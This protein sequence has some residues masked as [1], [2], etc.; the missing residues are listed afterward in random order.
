MLHTQRQRN[1]SLKVTKQSYCKLLFM[2]GRSQYPLSAYEIMNSF[3]PLRTSKLPRHVYRMVKSLSGQELIVLEG[4][5]YRVSR[6]PKYLNVTLKRK[7]LDEI[8]TLEKER[9][10][11]FHQIIDRNFGNRLISSYAPVS[12]EDEQAI[13]KV[14]KMR[15]QTR[16]YRYSLSIRGLLLF[17]Y[18]ES[19]SKSS[20][21]KKGRISEVLESPVTLE[22]APFLSNW[23]YFEQAG[24]NVTKTLENLAEEHF[25]FTTDENVDDDSLLLR[26]IERYSNQVFGHFYLY[27]R[28]GILADKIRRQNREY[29]RKYIEL[30]IPNKLVEYRIKILNIQKELL[31]K[32]L[33]LVEQRIEELRLFKQVPTFY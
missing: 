32:K 26:V 28:L 24:F 1:T 21:G 18:G 4:K 22:V 33:G 6:G 3:N 19:P 30:D 16:N 9:N 11:N 12:Y 29:F 27:E 5:R 15:S 14:E 25:H 10:K 7:S 17:L 2:V 31:S 23:K 13:G 20:A 8:V